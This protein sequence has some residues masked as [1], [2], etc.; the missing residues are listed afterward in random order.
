MIKSLNGDAL[1]R[2]PFEDINE[3][4]EGTGSIADIVDLSYFEKLCED[5]IKSIEKFGSFEEFVE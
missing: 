1:E 3:A 5:A 4:L 2:M